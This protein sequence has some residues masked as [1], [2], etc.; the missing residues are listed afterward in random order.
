MAP[1]T[2]CLVVGCYWCLVF[3]FH[4]QSWHAL[5]KSTLIYILVSQHL[6]TYKQQVN[7]PKL[8]TPRWATEGYQ[9]N[10][11]SLRKDKVIGRLVS[12][13][14]RGLSNARLLHLEEGKKR[15]Q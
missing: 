3:P 14:E 12:G 5:R 13:H 7:W 9:E 15:I 2:V 10:I 6:L 4:L 1:P 11:G 8:N